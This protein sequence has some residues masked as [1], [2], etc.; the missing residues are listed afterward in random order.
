MSENGADWV[1]ETKPVV[2][3]VIPTREA[4]L[5]AA[6]SDRLRPAAEDWAASRI[7]QRFS[8][9]RSHWPEI[10]AYDERALE[11]ERRVQALNDEIS[12]R[13]Q[14]LRAAVEADRQALVEWQLSDGKRRRPEPTAPAI[15]R[16]IEQKRADRDAANAAR[17]RVFED[18]AR[19]VEKNR[20]R[21]VREADRQTRKA[22]A[23]YAQA[24]QEAEQARAELIDCRSAAL[25][26][27]LFPGEL[28]NQMPDVAGVA[29]NLRKPVEAALGITTRLAADGVFRVLR[30][31]AEILPKA[32]TRDQALELGAADPHQNAAV[33]TGTPEWEEEMR[34][35]RRQARERYRQMWGRYPD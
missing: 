6:R 5:A 33:W 1:V 30:S 20:G 11:L 12:A 19:F 16:E 29:T 21:L 17:D 32:M 22:H 24:V 9:R 35:E 28:A 13:E 7:F 25:W 3:A 4:R 14:A 10:G 26:A 8:P 31:D 27:S 23:R 15:E 34:K 2:S 18:K